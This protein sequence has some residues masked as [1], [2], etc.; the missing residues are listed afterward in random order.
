MNLT[1]IEY[2]IRICESGSITK[3]ADRLFITQS[4]LSQQLSHLE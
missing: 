3:A 1:Q 4:A 2:F